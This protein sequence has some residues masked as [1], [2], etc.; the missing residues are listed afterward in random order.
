M[1][2]ERDERGRKIAGL[3]EVWYPR[4]VFRPTHVSSL[5]CINGTVIAYL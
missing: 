5:R 1:D 4:F 3:M 2:K